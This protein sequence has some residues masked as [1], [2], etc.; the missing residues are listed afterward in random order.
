MIQKFVNYISYNKIFVYKQI[1]NY[2]DKNLILYE[3]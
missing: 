2:R 3:I 1:I